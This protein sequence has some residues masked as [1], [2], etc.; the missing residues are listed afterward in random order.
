[1]KTGI[2]AVRGVMRRHLD[3]QEVDGDQLVPQV[4][5][6]LRDACRAPDVPLAD[7][8]EAPAA[9]NACQRRGDHAGGRQRVEGDVDR[10]CAGEFGERYAR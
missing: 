1:M 9:G 5:A 7:L 6:L 2:E 4:G 3:G 8:R 10:S